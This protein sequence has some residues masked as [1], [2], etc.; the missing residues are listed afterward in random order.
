MPM[1]VAILLSSYFRQILAIDFLMALYI[2]SVV[3]QIVLT[4]SML[5]VNKSARSNWVYGPPHYNSYKNITI[6]RR[7]R[8]LVFISLCSLVMRYVELGSIPILD[9]ANYKE[10]R[11]ELRASLVYTLYTVTMIGVPLLIFSAQKSDRGLMKR[12]K[13]LLALWFICSAGS[14]WTGNVAY[15]IIMSAAAFAIGARDKAREAKPIGLGLILI[16]VAFFGISFFRTV[17]N[18]CLERDLA[19]LMDQ[20]FWGRL[21]IFFA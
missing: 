7:L 3:M 10:A 1:T 5:A 21:F 16:L 19:T 2:V 4:L 6:R 15:P 13:L 20:R 12:E 9:L 11:R 17:V 8:L 18:F 14:G